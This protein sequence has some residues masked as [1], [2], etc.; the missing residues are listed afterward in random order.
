VLMMVIAS[1]F[2]HHLAG[3]G[4]VVGMWAYVKLQCH[5]SPKTRKRNGSLQI[6]NDGKLR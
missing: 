6:D 2:V 5:V 3:L 1:L 4:V